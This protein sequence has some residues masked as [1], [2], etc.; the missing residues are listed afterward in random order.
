MGMGVGR[1]SNLQCGEYL[2]PEILFCHFERLDIN[3]T[4]PNLWKNSWKSSFTVNPFKNCAKNQTGSQVTGG[5]EIQKNPAKNRVK[6]L[7]F[8]GSKDL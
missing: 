5:L 7:G 2:D 1:A 3:W 6:P 4:I 8:G